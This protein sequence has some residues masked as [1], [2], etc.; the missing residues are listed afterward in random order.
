[1]FSEI[2]KDYRNKLNLSMKDLSAKLEIPYRTW[3]DWENDKSSPVRWSTRLLLKELDSM[4]EEYDK[5]I[6][7]YKGKAWGDLRIPEQ[8]DLL[9]EA[10]P[11]NAI[12]GNDMNE[13]GDCIIDLSYLLSVPGKLVNGEI[14]IDNDSIIYDAAD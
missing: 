11:I 12:T 2:L 13:D 7:D 5:M 1:M 9:K 8:R 14:V 6:E 10:N 3:Q 4:V